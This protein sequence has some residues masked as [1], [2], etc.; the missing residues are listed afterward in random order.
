MSKRISVIKLIFLKTKIFSN[1]VKRRL[2]DN[3]AILK[4]LINIG[5]LVFFVFKYFQ[6]STI[7]NTF[8]STQI[9]GSIKQQSEAAILRIELYNT[10][11]NN[12]FTS[13]NHSQRLYFYGYLKEKNRKIKK[14]EKETDTLFIPILPQTPDSLD[15]TEIKFKK[16]II[17]HRDYYDLFKNFPELEKHVTKKKVEE[18]SWLYVSLLYNLKATEHEVIIKKGDNVY[19]DYYLDTTIY[20]VTKRITNSNEFKYQ[21]KHFCPK[22]PRALR[23]YKHLKFRNLIFGRND[24]SQEILNF[25]YYSTSMENKCKLRIELSSDKTFNILGS[26]DP[27]II[28]NKVRKM[29]DQE[30]DQR[31]AKQ[32]CAFMLSPTSGVNN[33]KMTMYLEYPQYRNLQNARVFFLTTIIVILLDRILHAISELLKN[34]LKKTA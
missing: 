19:R 17:H 14:I 29:Y 2:C 10:P 18:Y 9:E 7:P 4:L 25:E 30:T 24:I 22:S 34:K 33:N 13:V 26:N 8:F 21:Q 11:Q 20:S 5:L 12:I 3:K 28:D 6:I 15:T 32:S 27:N 16:V 1:W 31:A 23:K